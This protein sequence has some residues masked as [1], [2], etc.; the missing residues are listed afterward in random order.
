[1]RIEGLHHAQITIPTGTEEEG[2]RFYCEIMGLVEIEKPETLQHCGDFWL[3]VHVG[4]EDGV[5]RN[6][7]KA[8]VA[9]KVDDLAAWQSYL[10][11]N[12]II[13]LESVTIPGFT[14][15]EARDHFG[16]RFE[17]IQPLE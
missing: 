9:Y 17:C 13:I 2:R 14:R 8:H 12:G 16:N 11:Q 4:T 7:S 1:M 6:A 10:E 15:F 3:Q 5:E